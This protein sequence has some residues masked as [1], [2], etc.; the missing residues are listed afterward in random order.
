MSGGGKRWV[1]KLVSQKSRSKI[2]N[3]NNTRLNRYNFFI[4]FCGI[5]TSFH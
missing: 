3:T 5:F 4:G 2:E 1:R